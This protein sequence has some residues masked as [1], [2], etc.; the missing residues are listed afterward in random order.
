[1]EFVTE[2]AS[3]IQK[4]IWEYYESLHFKNLG[5]KRNEQISKLT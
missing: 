1:M 4:V 3:E 5:N 2:D